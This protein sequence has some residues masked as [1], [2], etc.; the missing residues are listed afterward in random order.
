MS[1]SHSLCFQVISFGLDRHCASSPMSTMGTKQALE[2]SVITSAGR[3]Y[4]NCHVPLPQ[5]EVQPAMDATRPR[6]NLSKLSG[7]FLQINDAKHTGNLRITYSVKP[8]ISQRYPPIDR[9]A[10]IRPIGVELH[11]VGLGYGRPRRCGP[12]RSN[13]RGCERWQRETAAAPLRKIRADLG[14]VARTGQGR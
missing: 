8:H 9:V 12:G 6:V 7:M 11:R 4:A 3:S 10:P 13:G 5:G 2:D 1:V 14:K